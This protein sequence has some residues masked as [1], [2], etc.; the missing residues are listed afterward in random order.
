MKP[1]NLILTDL[2]E[3]EEA[4]IISSTDGQKATQRLADLGL[5]PDTKIKVIT[6]AFF[7][8]L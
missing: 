1:K 4:K 5:T 7:L 6:K 8:G 3:G 2:K